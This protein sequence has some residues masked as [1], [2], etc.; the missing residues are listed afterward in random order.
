MKNYE[1]FEN[2]MVIRILNKID[3]INIKLI[4]IRKLKMKNMKLRYLIKNI[5]N[6]N[7]N[8]IRSDKIFNLN[9]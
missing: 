7:L 3:K 4:I 6:N 5:T 9:P 1:I 8:K 2:K